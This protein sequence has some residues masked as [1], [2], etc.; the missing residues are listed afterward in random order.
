MQ[1]YIVDVFAEEK[2]QGNQLA[3]FIPDRDVSD[4]E[5]QQ[6]AVETGFA[7]TSFILSDKKSNGGYDVRIFTPGMEVPFAG[8]PTL[9]TAFVIWSAL[10][11][12]ASE[13]VILNLKVGQIPVTVKDGRFTMSQNE[14]E[15]GA[16]IEKSLLAEVLSV[17]PEDIREDYPAQWV[18]TGLGSIIVPLKSRAA[19]V[20][21]HVNH[22]AFQRFIEEHFKCNILVFVPESDTLRVRVFTDDPGFPEDAATGSA[23]GNLAGYLL[24][25]NFFGS[26]E[27][28]YQV[29]QGVEMGRPSLLHV[30]ASLKADR[31]TIL[32]GGNVHFVAEGKWN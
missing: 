6:I 23:N 9:G 12:R 1:F 19:L 18:S 3:V 8:H 20:Q 22:D 7:E 13:K 26:G 5:M 29:R 25:Y 17:Q 14:P 24:K 2:Y 10:E 32:V 11:Q 30:D 31:C 16:R 21:S 27:I 4:T 28:H 15:F